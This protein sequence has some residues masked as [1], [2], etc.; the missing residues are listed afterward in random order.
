MKL[1]GVVVL[2]CLAPVAFRCAVSQQTEKAIVIE[3][4]DALPQPS[5]AADRYVSG[6][7]SSVNGETIHYHSPDPDA[8]SALLVRGQDVAPSI[9]WESDPMP[10]VPGDFTQFI[11]LA[12]IEC[13]GFPGEVEIHNFDFLINGQRWFTFKNAR[14]DAAKNWKIT[15][16]NGSAL[17]FNATMTDKAGDL[18]GY[19]V[20]KAPAS[21]FPPGKALL[22]EVR[23][24]NSGSPDWYMTFQ[25]AFNFAPKVR[26]EPA[27]LR[28]AGREMQSL[29]LSLD[30]LIAGRTL[31]VHTPTQDIADAPLKIGANVWQIAVPKA[32][33]PETVTIR[34]KLN[35]QLVQTDNVEVAP[36]KTKKIYLL[37]YSHNDIGYTDLQADVERKQW[38]NLEQAMQLI[39][40]RR[41]TRRMPGTS[42]IWRRSGHW[43]VTSSRLRPHNGKKCS[44]MYEKGALG[45]VHF[46][47]TC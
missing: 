12:G 42:G 13:G 11:W 40:R 44:P 39:P 15:G 10:D 2:A 21:D 43:R 45:S 9:S 32:T 8:D 26:A 4:K 46:T 22:F 35:G 3:V 33:S 14:G 23:G 16:R 19:M 34:F 27:L 20:L 36:V 29:R 38:K 41:I 17:T 1:S 30:N 7:H 37:C 31:S 24:D 25:H 47:P 6:Y 28:D 18:F 5:A